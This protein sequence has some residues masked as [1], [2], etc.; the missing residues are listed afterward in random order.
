M[1]VVIRQIKQIKEKM[2]LETKRKQLRREMG[3]GCDED[4]E[5][6]D[7]EEL[8]DFDVESVCQLLDRPQEV[9]LLGA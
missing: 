2:Q 3:L 9:N 8:T 7:S 1:D 6:G 5:Q 4:E